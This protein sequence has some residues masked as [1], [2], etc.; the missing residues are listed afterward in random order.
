[1]SL[2]TALG[3]K[4]RRVPR[5]KRPVKKNKAG[6]S[7]H[8]T[9]NP[10]FNVIWDKVRPY[11]MT[12]RARAFALWSAVNTVIDN[13]TQG[14]FVECGVWKG[15]SS[16]L[17]ALTLLSR[18]ITD[19]DLFL[20]DTFTGMTP[21]GPADR[22]L[23][24]RPAAALLAGSEGEALAELIR[25]AAPLEGVQQ[26]MESTGYDI[27]RIRFVVGDVRQTLVQTQTL[28]IAL[29]RLDTDFYDSTMAELHT[30]YP[31]LAQG[32]VLIVDDYGHWQGA[33]K[34]VDEYF[35]DPKV[36]FARPMLWAIDYTGRGG[37][38]MEA[39]DGEIQRYDYIPPGMVVPDLSPIFSHAQPRDP[40]PVKW[41]YLRKE[42]PHIWRSDTRHVGAFIVGN[43]SIEEAACLYSFAKQFAGRRG[44]EIGTHFGWTAAH[45][46]AAGVRLDCIDPAFADPARN[47]AINE[48]LD[49]VPDSRG[50]RL[51]SGVS[52]QIVKEARD[53][54]DEP[55]SFAFIDGD[56]NGNA[57]ANDAREVL[58]Y[59]APDAMVV[60]HDLTSP[61]VELGLAVFREAGFST[62]LI[63]TMQVLGVA[64]RGNVQAPDH[65]AD[66]KVP[67]LVAPH[68]Q[69]YLH[70]D[71]P[72]TAAQNPSGSFI[73]R[74]LRKSR[75]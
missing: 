42:V 57:P 32:G 3:L 65:I 14:A 58:K 9:K 28:G 41:D 20:F 39:L 61:D 5:S 4:Q 21:P 74:F 53:S 68:L 7:Q 43:A 63:N 22:D 29:L 13:G 26:A 73:S 31:R 56:H 75:K 40:W 50:Y 59:L 11:T 27:R 62:R 66:A 23:E 16:M 15:G 47:S 24:D 19:R 67:V 44:L 51:W 25:A 35:A 34:A 52:P 54:A 36:P 18:G 46:L 33:Q 71:L 30:L 70:S 69:K 12:S 60:F 8:L 55:W 64:W 10:D 2:R 38:K 48:A 72:M 1:M 49:Q 37:V 6:F 17:I 45:L